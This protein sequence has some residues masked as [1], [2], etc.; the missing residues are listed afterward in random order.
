MSVTFRQLHPLFFG[1]ASPIDL[2]TVD[3]ET[4]LAEI[5]AGMDQYGVLVFHD[6]EFTDADQ[7]AFAHRFDGE[8][9]TKTG[10]SVLAKSR[11]GNEALSDISNLDENG[12]IMRSDDRRRMYTLG[13]RLW[14]TDASFQDPPG[15]YSM[16]HARIVPTVP[17]DT[18]Y[19]DM[20]SAYDAL[21]ADTKALIEDLRVHHSIAHS[22]RF[23]VWCAPIRAPGA[24][25]STSPPTPPASSTGR[26]PRGACYYANCSITAPNLSFGTCISGGWVTW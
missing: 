11:L 2:R 23:T 21:D 3:D 26:C 19:A 12:E 1:E 22:A 14:H 16:L 10:S 6:Q 25:R 17:A 7:L 18:E 15:R 9:H 8:L 13:N 24:D 4:I 5:R 20:R